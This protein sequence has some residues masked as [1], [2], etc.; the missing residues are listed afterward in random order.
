MYHSH[1]FAWHYHNIGLYVPTIQTTESKKV[2]MNKAKFSNQ[3]LYD[4][5]VINLDIYD[6]HI[7]AGNDKSQ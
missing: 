3:N 5:D 6:M 2:L 1:N 4:K 7:N